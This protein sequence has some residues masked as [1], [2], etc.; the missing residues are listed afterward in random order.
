MTGTID[1]LF[2]NILTENE[3]I[4]Q[5]NFLMSKLPAHLAEELTIHHTDTLAQIDEKKKKAKKKLKYYTYFL[6][7]YPHNLS[8]M[9]D[10]KKDDPDAPNVTPVAQ[11]GDT[12][13]STHTGTG[14]LSNAGEPIA[15]AA[16][17]PATPTSPSA[18]PAV[19]SA[20]GEEDEDA[21]NETAFEYTGG[22]AQPVTYDPFHSFTIKNA[23]DDAGV[24]DAKETEHDEID[25]A[26]SSTERMRRYNR[27]HPEK[28]RK[29]LR[30]TQGDRVARNRD[31]KKA[32]KKYGKSKM[33]NHDVHHPNGPH[34]GKWKLAKKDHGPDKKHVNEH[35]LMEGGAAGHLAH[36]Y[37]DDSLKFSDVKEMIKRGLVGGLDAEAPVTEKLDGQN[38]TFSVRDNRVV[39]ARN[40][41][42][43]KNRGKNALDAAGLRQMFAGRGNVEKAFGGAADDLQKAVDALP[44]AERTQ[45]FADGAKFMNVE[46]ILPDTKNVIP[47]DKSVLVFH[48]TIE[49]DEEGNEVGRNIEDSKIL[50]NALMR[51]NAQQQ[52][53]FGISGPRS[54]SFSDA[55]TAQNLKHMKEYASQIRR[56]QDEFGLSDKS[57]IEDY[58]KAWWTRE[59]DGMGIDWTPEEKEGLIS[60]WAT[61]EKK[62]KV[63]DIEDPE[64]KK[65][66]REYEK[67]QLSDAQKAATRPL[68]SVFLRV[69]ADT[70]KRVTNFLSANNPELA[71][72]LKQELKDTIEQIK[73]ANDENQLAMLQKQIERLDDIG[74]D[75]VVPTEGLVFM[76][77]GKPYK[78]TGSFAPVNQILGMMKFERGKAKVTEPKEEP[79]TTAPEKTSTQAPTQKPTQAPAK[80]IAIF[81]G[82]FQPFHSGHYS[83]YK[84]LVDKFGKDNVYIATSDKVEPITSPFGFK[85]KQNIMSKMFDIP[86]DKIV[87]TKAPYRPVEIT[88][89]LPENTPVVLSFSEK[90]AER[91]QGKYFKPYKDGEK[92]DGYRNHGYVIIAPEM[93]LDIDGKNVSGTQLRYIFGN[94]Q[95]TDRAKEEIFTKV[96]GKFDDDIFNKIVKTT[97]KAEEARK[98]T[99][100]YGKE[101][102]PAPVKKPVVQ[103]KVAAK[104][105]AKVQPKVRAGQPAPSPAKPEQQAISPIQ[106][107][108]LGNILIQKILNPDTKK[109][110]LVAT[111]LK[112]PKD[113]PSYKQAK[114]MVDRI[115]GPSKRISQ[116]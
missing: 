27:R 11:K 14:G 71:A 10:K 109:D 54:I 85:D 106:R 93:K 63:S 3:Y 53:T 48:G 42:Q 84:S 51:V 86:A 49:Y 88:D 90:D 91:M 80:P 34:G 2:E 41:G 105:Q 112:Y 47:Y 59:I 73:D 18:A 92:L 24:D 56:I 62:F 30:D 8:T 74:I 36:P 96:Y 26:M 98:L 113:H 69:G 40:K 79:T 33:K 5:H 38:I 43:V 68:E 89:K 94:P 97:T 17:N 52:K 67:T 57:T 7:L 102:M 103:P 76:Y 107:Q 39:F 82:R 61:G 44:E 101:K 75:N 104:P 78:F 77:N 50:S 28:V 16:G 58:K 13:G 110:I 32:V 111:A 9:P 100:M 116:K 25:E 66:F 64:K 60:R 29:Y 4:D 45:M 19:A 55:D 20:P 114:G 35:Y 22:R 15:Q 70:L 1:K 72:R 23:D 115:L 99:D 65:F 31:R 6:P 108:K 87:Q 46:I 12:M 83:I 81:P 21:K 95:F 37:E